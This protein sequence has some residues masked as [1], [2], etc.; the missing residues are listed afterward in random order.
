MSL[1][2]Y[3]SEKVTENP[4]SVERR[5][6]EPGPC[7]P[8]A[9]PRRG[10]RTRAGKAGLD[11]PMSMPCQ[12]HG[13]DGCAI[14]AGRAVSALAWCSAVRIAALAGPDGSTAGYRAG[15]WTWVPSGVS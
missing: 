12:A 7:C 10:L 13:P 3:R 1:R 8:V 4:V 2:E 15:G 6:A 9:S 11:G 14:R 5:R